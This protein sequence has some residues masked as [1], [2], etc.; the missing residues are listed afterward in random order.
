VIVD[1]IFDDFFVLCQVFLSPLKMRVITGDECGLLKESIPE[2]SRQNEDTAKRPQRSL[3]HG[4]SILGNN[5]SDF[6]V[7]MSRPRAVVKLAFCNSQLQENGALSFAALRLD[8]SLERWDGLAPYQSK[9]DRMCGGSYKIAESMGNVFAKPKR[10]NNNTNDIWHRGRPIEMCSIPNQNSTEESNIV[11]CCSS[12]GSIAIVDVHKMDEG[13]VTRHAAFSK[14]QTNST[15]SNTKGNVVNKD[16]ATTMA[17][18]HDGKRIA[19]GGR[20]R[21]VTLTHAETGKNLWKAKSLP[22][23]PQTLLQQPT[24]STAMQFLSLTDTAPVH[25][26]SN[27]LAIGTAYK[28]LQIYDMRVNAVQRRPIAYT[29]EWDS[30][31]SNLLNHRVTSLCQL[32]SNQILVGDS[33]G[34]MNTIDLRKLSNKHGRSL[35]ASVGRFC[36]PSGS[37]RQ[38]LKH[39]NQP[40]I[41]CIGL[42][43]MLRTFDINSRKQ[44]DCVYLKQRLNCMLFCSDDTWKD[45]SL[46]LEHDDERDLPDDVV[47]SDFKDIINQEDEVEDYVDSSD[48]DNV[49]DENV[50]KDKIETKYVVGSDD[51]EDEDSSAEEVDDD[52]DECSLETNSEESESSTE[53]IEYE[54]TSS[55]RHPKR[56]RRR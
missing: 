49:F 45:T 28:Q 35:S 3:D 46:M 14:N 29:P 23:N 7:N 36:G 20:E 2:L 10:P 56:P 17:V 6:G 39:G 52:S 41:T 13:V 37:V 51:D 50:K 15:I 11:A 30:T 16:T 38:I 24:W 34:Y 26:S 21:S 44:L 1:A 12:M 47:L 53:E 5:T 4:V 18:D 33:A 9:D 42:D 43:R 32:D 48:D 55:F 40:I 25:E 22:P 27:L 31:K 54:E 19:V 8:G